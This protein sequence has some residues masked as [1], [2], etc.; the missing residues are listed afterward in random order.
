MHKYTFCLAI[1][2]NCTLAVAQTDFQNFLTYA[3][4]LSTPA[5]K[6]AAVDSFM[7][8]ARTKGIPFI[9]G[10]TVNFI[11]R[12]SGSSVVLS[13]DMN[14]WSTS[15][16]IRKIHIPFPAVMARIPS[17]PCRSMFSRGR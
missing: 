10:D 2:L 9:E 16:A 5:E 7:A 14:G 17:L 6:S 12:G 1:L 8:Y 4:S 13:G 11:Y 3:N 15:A